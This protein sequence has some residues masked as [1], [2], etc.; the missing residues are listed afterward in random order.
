MNDYLIFIIGLLLLLGSAEF[1]IRYL[2]NIATAVGKS[3]MFIGLTLAAFGT[4]APELA[5]GITGLANGQA[6]I[7]LGNIIGSNIFNIFF[8][9]GLA[10]LVKPIIVKQKT[11]QRDVPI[12]LGTSLLFFILAVGG[13]QIYE[14]LVLFAVLTGYLV[15]LSKV[16][17]DFE[18][19]AEAKHPDTTIKKPTVKQIIYSSVMSVISL[20]LLVFASRLMVESSINIAESFGVSQLIIGLTIVAIG[21]SLPEIATTLAAI[22][23]NEYELAIG[24]I[25]GSC[26]FNIAAVPAAMSLV[27]FKKL[28]IAADAMYIDIPVMVLAVLV[29]LPILFSGHLVSRREG[30][31]FL[32]YYLMYAFILFTRNQPDFLFSDYKTELFI[33]MGIVL[34]ITVGII[35]YR[36][37]TY[38][39]K[40]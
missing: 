30:G 8:V 9:L 10:A 39:K 14:A 40:V 28:P 24:N 37:I 13:I 1:F 17:T 2:T 26:M 33:G 12:V 29:C 5:I 19:I 6:D 38:R 21:T 35:S 3:K 7:G 31:L 11:I 16:S 4:S 32:L 36:A 15:Y 22:R 18:S 34:M 23:K 27:L 20:G 25:M